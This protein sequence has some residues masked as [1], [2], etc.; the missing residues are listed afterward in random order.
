MY[1]RKTPITVTVLETANPIVKTSVGVIEKYD[2]NTGWL[3]FNKRAQ[4]NIDEAKEIRNKGMGLFNHAKYMMVIDTRGTYANGSMEALN[5][6]ALDEKL[7]EL[8]IAQAIIVDNLAVSLLANFYVSIMSRNS[9]V[10]LFKNEVEA[11]QWLSSK[12]T[13]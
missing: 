1:I 2:H 7:N 3:K 5:Y 11:I 6:L 4:V 13:S 12:E 9:N 8:C 10:K